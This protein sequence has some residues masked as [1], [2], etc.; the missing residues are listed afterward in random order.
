MIGLIAS[1]RLWSVDGSRSMNRLYPRTAVSSLRY[2]RFRERTRA[3]S[4]CKS[5]TPAGQ[6]DLDSPQGGGQLTVVSAYFWPE[7]TGISQVVWELAE[8]LAARGVEVDVVTAMPFYPAWRIDD[9]YRRRIWSSEVHHDVRIRRSWHYVR[10]APSTFTRLL[11]EATLALF[12]LPNLVL[13][14]RRARYAYI[15][16]PQLTFAWVASLVARVMRVE[17]TLVVQDV[18]PDAAVELGMLKSKTMI[19]VSRWFARTL[20]N[21][22]DEISTLSEG[23]KRRIAVLCERPS[24]I[25][26]V[27]NTIDAE[28]LKA[29]PIE[30]NEFRRRF[31]PNGVFAVL[32]TGNMGQ[33]QDL[34]LLLSAA[35]LLRDDPRVRFFV[36]GDGAERER[37]LRRR[38]ELKLTNVEQHPLQERWLLPH[39]L[40]GA[41][42][43]LVSQLPEVTDLVV[44]SKLLTA[45][46][47]GAAIV[48][49]CHGDSEVARLLTE[50]NGGIVIPASDSQMLVSVIRRISNDPDA[51]SE[52]RRSAR[53]YAKAHFARHVVFDGVL[54]RLRNR[55][56]TVASHRM[57]VSWTK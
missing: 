20:Y 34:D 32:H 22:A 30:S 28:E 40:S 29:P 43:V 38:S 12:A 1:T 53:D 10:P 31:V 52:Y 7:Q 51:M 55:M 27:P 21:A 54:G 49:A 19:G 48:A 11:H 17:F 5:M 57:K 44:P 39:M 47:A 50:A 26:L 45:M 36:F 14:L 18:M 41:D 6:H 35:Q 13:S 33:K 42:L 15:V 46:G 23:M 2:P 9:Q 56:S 25:S 8:F 37:F 3:S 16:S 4:R 24:P